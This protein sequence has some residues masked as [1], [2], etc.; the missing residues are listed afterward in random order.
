M[1]DVAPLVAAA[2]TASAGDDELAVAAELDRACRDRGFFL[3]TGHGVDPSVVAALD[4]AARAFFALDDE[5]KAA[6]GMARGGRAWRGWFPLDG[7]LTAGVPDRKEGFYLGV[8]LSADDPRV[9]AGLPLHGPNLYPATPAELRPAAEAWIAAATGVGHALVRGLGLALG[10]GPRWFADHLTGD[11]TV[12]AR[13]FRYPAA[14][15]DRWGVAEHT[16]YGLVTVLAH[17]G[18]PGLEVRGPQGWEAVPAVADAFVVNLGDMLEAMTG[19]RYR[20]TPHRVA[21][22]TD[23]PDRLSF[24]VFFD[25]S[26]DA[27]VAPLPLDHLP[28]PRPDAARRWDGTQVDAWTGRYGDYLTAKVAR[29]FPGLGTEVLGQPQV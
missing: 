29:V 19:G 12:L 10:L 23:G 2:G 4:G 24:P 21:S 20:S 22:A 27:H 6:V 3:I 15:R 25:P 13:I 14:D 1:I 28:P 9:V 5:A 11:P 18:R 17:D 7:E 8:D 16:D 26:W